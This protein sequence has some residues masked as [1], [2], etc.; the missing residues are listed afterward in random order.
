MSSLSPAIRSH[1]ECNHD[2]KVHNG[3]TQYEKSLFVTYA[4]TKGDQRACMEDRIWTGKLNGATF[5]YMLLDGHNGI[6]AVE[7]VCQ[8]FP[9]LLSRNLGFEY[10]GGATR[11]GI[12]KGREVRRA[13]EQSFQEIHDTL[14]D[15]EAG[16][17]MSIVLS[18]GGRL[19]AANVGDS[20]IY[21]VT[22][23]ATQPLFENHNTSA[24]LA[25]RTR[26]HDTGDYEFDENKYA[27]LK[28][29]SSGLAMSRAIGDKTMGA[30]ILQKPYVTL[31]KK[32]FLFI[33]M[34]SDGFFDVVQDPNPL[35]IWAYQPHIELSAA[36]VLHIRNNLRDQHDNI[37]IMF[38]FGTD[39]WVMGKNKPDE[40]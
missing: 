7:H 20:P 27:I 25:E 30:G 37:S 13:I 12:K 21:R 26:L 3:Y 19:W 2:S 8:H 15:E 16:T 28:G 11:K 40:S 24:N 23:R 29:G 36:H 14:E 33:A 18:Y 35:R 34:G 9:A 1:P 22:S 4:Y 17:T 31:I 5:L 10:G 39:Q 6:G 38:L 32:P